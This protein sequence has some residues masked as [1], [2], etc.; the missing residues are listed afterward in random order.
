MNPMRLAV[1]GQVDFIC[2]TA[3]RFISNQPPVFSPQQRNQRQ[4]LLKKQVNQRQVLL[5]QQV[6]ERQLSLRQQTMNRVFRKQ[7]P[8]KPLLFMCPTTKI[9]KQKVMTRQT[10]PIGF[11]KEN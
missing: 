7:Q 6:K 9:Q 1:V 11:P 5:K 4:V 3:Q 8:Y 10:H 2:K